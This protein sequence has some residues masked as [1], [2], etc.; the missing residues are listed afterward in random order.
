MT[1]SEMR[2]AVFDVLCRTCP[3]ESTENLGLSA[4]EIAKLL[5]DQGFVYEISKDTPTLP[6]RGIE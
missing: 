4:I 2:W 1:R 6:V 5:G 3:D